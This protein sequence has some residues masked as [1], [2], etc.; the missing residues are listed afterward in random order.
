MVKLMNAF[1]AARTGIL[2]QRDQLLKEFLSIREKRYAIV[3]NVR[4]GN[5]YEILDCRTAEARMEVGEGLA[6]FS[7]L[8]ALGQAMGWQAVDKYYQMFFDDIDQSSEHFYRLG[9]LQVFSLI[10]NDQT[11]SQVF[12]KILKSAD[13]IAAIYGQ[14]KSVVHDRHKLENIVSSVQI[15]RKDP[16]LKNDYNHLKT[17]AT[18]WIER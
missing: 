2:A 9:S 1:I 8:W 18:R 15:A 12:D 17:G 11:K 7:G 6:D 10:S 14:I 4:I 3:S 13:P 5:A 16:L